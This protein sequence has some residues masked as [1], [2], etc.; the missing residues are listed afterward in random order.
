M[1]FLYTILVALLARCEHGTQRRSQRTRAH[2]RRRARARGDG[3]PDGAAAG[4]RAADH[5]EGAGRI[6]DDAGQA[7]RPVRAEPDRFAGSRRRSW[8]RRAA[9]RM[10]PCAAKPFAA[11]ASAETRKSLDALAGDLQRRRRRRE[12]GSAAGLADRR[13]QG[14]R[15]SGGAE[16]QNGGGS[17]RSD[18]HARRDGRD[19]RAAQARRSAERL[20]A[21][22]WTRMRSAAISRA[23]ARS[24]RAAANRSVRVE[25]VRKIGIIDS[26]AAR[27]ALREIYSRST[28]AEIKEAA[29]QGMLIA[30]DEQGVLA[31]YRAAKTSRGEASAA[32]YADDDGRRRRVAGHRCRAG[33]QEMKLVY[34]SI[35]AVALCL[36]SLALAPQARSAELTLPRDGWASWQVAAV[37]GAPAWCCWSRLQTTFATHRGRPADSTTSSDNFGNRDDATTDTVRVYARTAGGK[38][39]RLRVLSATCPVEAATPI[40]DLGNV[41]EDDSARW[42]IALAKRR[43]DKD[44]DRESAGRAGDASRRRRARCVGC[45][46]PQRHSS[47]D[48]QEGRLLAR[49]CCAATPAPTSRP[50]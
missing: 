24:P 50:P 42:L 36:A 18:S 46:R 27:A 2:R 7:A 32:A 47:R 12:G 38:I 41:A 14:G 5:Q 25:A 15:V 35:S 10:P 1:R 44:V 29:L 45:H 37:E 39:E 30:G 28:D 9:R 16:C 31:L 8:S 13:A 23:C 17:D 4:A 21:D 33:G 19:R 26:D 40:R 22:W 20:A 11:S 34:R 48:S 43:P 6:A 49:P 3:R